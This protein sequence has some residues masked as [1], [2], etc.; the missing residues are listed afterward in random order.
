MLSIK[1]HCWGNSGRSFKMVLKHLCSGSLHNLVSFQEYWEFKG[2]PNMRADRFKKGLSSYIHK[3]PQSTL[4][5]STDTF[6]TT[7][8]IQALP[9]PKNMRWRCICVFAESVHAALKSLLLH[10]L[11]DGKQKSNLI[12]NSQKGGSRICCSN[13]TLPLAQGHT[14][15]VFAIPTSLVS[16]FYCIGNIRVQGK[17]I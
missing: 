8:Q 17:T 11:S 13:V 2:N 3:L 9:Y 14:I 12:R 16:A 15:P 5:M 10:L 1:K 7:Y 6:Q 4:A